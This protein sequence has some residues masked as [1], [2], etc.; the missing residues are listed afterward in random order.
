MKDFEHEHFVIHDQGD[1]KNIAIK[2]PNGKVLSIGFGKAHYASPTTSEVAVWDEAGDKRWITD[3]YI[4]G[5]DSVAGWTTLGTIVHLIVR[6][7]I[8][9]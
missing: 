3:K 9:E 1:H 2:F 6:L 7:F 5:A 8:E 4:E